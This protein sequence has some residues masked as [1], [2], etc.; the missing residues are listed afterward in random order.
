MNIFQKLQF[1]QLQLETRRHF[2]R[3]CATGLGGMWL[4]L[5]GGKALGATG[6]KIEHDMSNPLAPIPPSFAPRAKKIIYI[7]MLGAPSQHELFVN[8]PALVKYNGKNCPQEFLQ[9]ER[10]AFI[11]GTPKLLGPLFDFKQHGQSGASIS[12]RFPHL[13]KHAD[14]L[15]FIHS[16]QTDQFNHGPAELLIHT[17]NVNLGHPAIGSWVT[18]GLGSPNNNLPGFMVLLSGGRLPRVGK[19]LWGSGYLPSVYQGIQCRSAGAPILNAENPTGVSQDLRRKTLNYLNDINEQTYQEIGDPETLTRIAQYEMAYRMQSSVPDIMDITKEPKEVH[20]MYGTQPGKESFA[21]NCLLTRKL[22]ENDV[23]FVQ[24]YDWGWD[25]HGSN[26]SEALNFGFVDKCMETDKP[27]AAL[28]TDLKQRGL[29]EETLVLW[30][31]EFGR[32]PMQENRAGGP[33]NFSG[34]DHNPNAFTMWMAGAGV[35]KGFSYGETDDLGYRV[36]KDPVSVPD[37]HAT[38]LHIMGYDHHDLSV[39]HLGLKQKLTGIHKA[40]VVKGILA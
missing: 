32:T 8:K 18:W 36:I 3:N 12:D 14:D 37:F 40:K 30:G 25:S 16:M 4:A 26:K 5:Q 21:N 11:Q 39:Q 7:H 10:F 34:R 28:L 24:L 13:A 38:L 6:L 2:L 19:S 33:G 31:G 23:R 15:C 22:V 29:L 35:K 9:G 17:G 1:E 27:I 20:E